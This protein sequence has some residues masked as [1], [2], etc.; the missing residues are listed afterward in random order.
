MEKKKSS[1]GSSELNDMAVHEGGEHSQR[2][3]DLILEAISTSKSAAHMTYEISRTILHPNA[4]TTNGAVKFA[5]LM[6]AIL[7]VQQSTGKSPIFIWLVSDLQQ[8]RDML[9]FMR[10]HEGKDTPESKD[11]AGAFDKLAKNAIIAV[12]DAGSPYNAMLASMA[13]RGSALGDVA[14]T[15]SLTGEGSFSYLRHFSPSSDDDWQGG[16]HCESLANVPEEL[17]DLSRNLLEA[18]GEKLSDSPGAGTAHLQKSK[19]SISTIAEILPVLVFCIL[20][21]DNVT[22]FGMM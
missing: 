19:I 10:S 7:K 16:P 8:I 3:R 13:Q 17:D 12:R 21:A 6:I 4:D 22:L 2:S 5:E 15:A 11:I 9:I 14:L 1:P 20:H 18:H